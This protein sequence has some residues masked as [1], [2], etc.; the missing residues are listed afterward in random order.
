MRDDD[1]AFRAMVRRRRRADLFEPVVVLGLLGVLV[2][3]LGW[4]WA[5]ATRP[6][7]PSAAVVAC[8]TMGGVLVPAYAAGTDAVCVAPLRRPAGDLE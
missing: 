2:L 5:R 3:G 6:E 7:A 1:A 4:V 8:R